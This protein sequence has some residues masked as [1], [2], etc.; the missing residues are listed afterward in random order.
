MRARVPCGEEVIDMAAM[1]A[2]QVER[3][4]AALESLANAQQC[5]ARAMERLAQTLGSHPAP[6]T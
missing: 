4:L 5:Q 6:T 1:T 2:Q 3:F